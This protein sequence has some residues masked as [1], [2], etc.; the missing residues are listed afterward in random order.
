MFASLV[1]FTAAAIRK[2]M[3]PIKIGASSRHITNLKQSI[4]E[5]FNIYDL[6][7]IKPVCSLMFQSYIDS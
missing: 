1:L 7:S 5:T 4:V 6:S 3:K 2:E